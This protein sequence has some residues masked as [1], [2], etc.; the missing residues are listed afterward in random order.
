V[1]EIGSSLREA[2]ERRGLQLSDVERDTRI[3]PRYLRALEEERFD[4]LPGR[5]YGK[6]F[7][8]TYADYLGLDADRFV[9]ELNSRLP[10]EEDE[11]VPAPPRRQLRRPA[12]SSAGALAAL[13]VAIVGAGILVW[14]L[15]AGGGHKQRAAPPPPP[16]KRTVTQKPATPPRTASR[17]TL[18]LRA[19]NG[20][21]WIEAHAGSQLGK[22]LYY[23]VLEQGRTLRLKQKRLWLRLGDPTALVATLDGK[24]LPLPASTPVDVVVTPAGLQLA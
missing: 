20:R 14:V 5:A 6:G 21:C 11:L 3:R 19:E 16:P 4:L 23:A 12:I 2:R 10:S 17:A 13:G 15:G 22:Q 1:F 8:R 7:L 24:A 18:V 9:D